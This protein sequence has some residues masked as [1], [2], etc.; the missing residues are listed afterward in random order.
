MSGWDWSYGAPPNK[1]HRRKRTGVEGKGAQAMAREDDQAALYRAGDLLAAQL[2]SAVVPFQLRPATTPETREAI[3]RLR[4]AVVVEHGW[5]EAA[6]M[7][8]GLEHDPFDDEALHLGAWDGET[9]AGTIR[10]VFPQ[11]GRLLPTEE[12]FGVR[13]PPH[14]RVVDAS[15]IAIDRG[16]RSATHQLLMAL[17]AQSWLEMR[18]R[19]Y[20]ELA[21]TA[22]EDIVALVRDLGFTTEILG[23][24]QWY[25]GELRVPFRFDMLATIRGLVAQWGGATPATTE[26]GA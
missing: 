20:Q 4:H 13:I 24:A 10:L 12:A 25:C 23:P 8:D 5:A 15:R 17:S 11:P 7:P 16:H 3:L 19:G 2:V 14:G 9:L 22:T 6:S 18:A 21:A 26:D 1:A